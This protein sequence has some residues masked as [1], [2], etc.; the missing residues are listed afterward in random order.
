VDLFYTLVKVMKKNKILY[1][2][3]GHSITVTK[4]PGPDAAPE[5]QTKLAQAVHWHTSF[6]M[7]I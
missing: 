3:L 1:R 2:L 6:Q 5:M 7:S 4:D